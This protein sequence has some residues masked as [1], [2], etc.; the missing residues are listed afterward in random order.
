MPILDPS[1]LA[2]TVIAQAHDIR[3]LAERVELLERANAELVRRAQEAEAK[4]AD[5]DGA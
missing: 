3:R 2:T 1:E 4:E 5:D